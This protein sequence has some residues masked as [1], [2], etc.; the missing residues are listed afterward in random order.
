MAK[1]KFGFTII[2]RDTKSKARLGILRTPHGI[3]RTPAY[4]M[5][6]TR[7]AVKTLSPGDLK[8][9]HTQIVIANAYHLRNEVPQKLTCLPARQEVKSQKLKVDRS[10]LI[11]KLGVS[12][13]TMTDS[14]GFQVFSLGAAKE[15]GVGKVLKK[16]EK[17]KVKSKKFSDVRITE[18][19]AH[20]TVDG[21]RQFMSPED[22]IKIQGKIGADVIFA[23]DECTSPLHSLFYTKKAMERTHRWAVQCLKARSRA[24]QQNQMLF[25]IVQGGRFRSL[26]T[27]SARFIGMLPFDGIG[28]GGSFGKNEM[29]H[30]LKAVVPHLPDEKPRHLLGIGAAEDI[31]NAIQEGIDLF[32][33]VIPTRE[34]RH[35]RIWTRN[36]PYNAKQ[37]KNAADAPLER[38]CTC[39]TCRRGI[40]RAKLFAL[41][42]AKSPDGGHFATMHNVWFFNTL[43]EDIRRAIR[44]GKFLT[45]KG[46]TLS[47]FMRNVRRSQISWRKRRDKVSQG[48]LPC[49][50]RGTPRTRP[51]RRAVLRARAP[52]L[53]KPAT[54]R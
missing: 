2:A 47:R 8:R 16:G 3:V 18:R 15:Y 42:K 30:T 26:R 54:R 6:A 22:S 53:S 31:F 11:K 14:G 9:T 17:L 50:R 25:G 7:G 34:A 13:P 36:G 23:F 52:G 35:G 37:R 10:F 20:F 4:V 28:I 21:K 1:Q 51:S 39:P 24:G 19:G 41:F 48:Y 38:G 46:K 12:M 27:A 32:D 29:V 5:V 44:Q 33:C 40:T 49:S 43:L 45:F